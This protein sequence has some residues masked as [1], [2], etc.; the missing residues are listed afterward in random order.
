MATIVGTTYVDLDLMGGRRHREGAGDIGMAV[1]LPLNPR[2][3]VIGTS[4]PP[5]PVRRCQRLSGAGRA[6]GRLSHIDIT[7]ISD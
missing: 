3:V 6:E 4:S 2:S 5:E 7:A 1:P